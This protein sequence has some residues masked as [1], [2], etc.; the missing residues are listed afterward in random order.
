MKKLLLL[1]VASA[2][3]LTSFAASADS[4]PKAGSLWIGVDA[5]LATLGSPTNAGYGINAGQSVA[6]NVGL[7]IST[8]FDNEMN[9]L[10][11]SYTRVSGG[12]TTVG[13]L[14]VGY[15]SVAVQGVHRTYSDRAFFGSKAGLA[16]VITK[17]GTGPGVNIVSFAGG[18]EGG[19]IAT[20]NLSIVGKIDLRLG[21]Q[22]V[23]NDTTLNFLFTVG[24]QYNF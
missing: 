1:C 7:V 23:N 8:P 4:R 12:K 2:I 17:V 11:L 13:N 24:A 22:A 16:N 19:Y 5:G 9:A 18:F 21:E 20:Q 3:S 15:T 14:D 6:G 10:E